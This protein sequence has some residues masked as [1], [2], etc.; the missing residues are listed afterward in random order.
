MILK[1]KKKKIHNHKITVVNSIEKEMKSVGPKLFAFNNRI[2]TKL[3]N[4]KFVFCLFD[5][6]TVYEF[7]ESCFM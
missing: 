4:I 6:N 1:K 5:R 2:L 7:N 3:S